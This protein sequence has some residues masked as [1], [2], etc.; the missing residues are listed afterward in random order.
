MKSEWDKERYEMEKKKVTPTATRHL[1]LIRHGNY[2]MDGDL[3][4]KHLLTALGTFLKGGILY[5]SI[6]DALSS[7]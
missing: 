7:Y 1:F 3:D 6:Q 5:V 4:E 2:S